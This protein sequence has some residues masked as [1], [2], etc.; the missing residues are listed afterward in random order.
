MSHDETLRCELKE[1]QII[2]KGQICKFNNSKKTQSEQLRDLGHGYLHI[3]ID[4]N[5]VYTKK[6]ENCSNAE[7][8]PN[9]MFTCPFILGTVIAKNIVK[10]TK[11]T[12]KNTEKTAGAVLSTH[13]FI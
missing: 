12:S 1:P 10:T 9:H 7:L 6:C 5:N 11:K 4:G 3:N 13:V 8:Y 2:I